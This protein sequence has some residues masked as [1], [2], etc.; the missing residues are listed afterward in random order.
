MNIEKAKQNLAETIRSTINSRM[1]YGGGNCPSGD[2]LGECAAVYET[3]NRGPE[4]WWIAHLYLWTRADDL[5][6]AK[7]AAWF[8]AFGAKDVCVR[9]V[10]HDPVN[11]IRNAYSTVDAVRPWDVSFRMTPNAAHNRPA[12]AGPG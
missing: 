3:D 2:S 7:V 11:D 5:A 9:A 1:T 4:S 6:P 8:E 12:S 10:L